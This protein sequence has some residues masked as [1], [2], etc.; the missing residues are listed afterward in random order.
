MENPTTIK[1][2]IFFEFHSVEIFK[3][4]AILFMGIAQKT[5]QTIVLAKKRPFL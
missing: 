2:N 5:K 4:T 3:K 1:K